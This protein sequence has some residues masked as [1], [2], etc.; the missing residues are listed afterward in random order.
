LAVEVIVVM[1]AEGLTAD[2]CELDVVSEMLTIVMIV[3]IVV[4]GIGECVWN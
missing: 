2:R 4:G 3:V 1:L